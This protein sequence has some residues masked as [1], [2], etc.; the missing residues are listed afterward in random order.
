MSK[1]ERTEGRGQRTEVR[2]QK[3]EGEDEE[4]GPMG[5]IGPMGGELLF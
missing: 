1:G 2:R 5:I 4:I 3:A